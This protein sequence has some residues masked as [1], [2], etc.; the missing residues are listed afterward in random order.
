VFLK[1]PPPLEGKKRGKGVSIEV[2]RMVVIGFVLIAG[3][4]V[5]RSVTEKDVLLESRQEGGK[6]PIVLIVQALKLRK[7]DKFV[8]DKSKPIYHTLQKELEDENREKLAIFESYGAHFEHLIYD[9]PIFF[10]DIFV[11]TVHSVCSSESA[12]GSYSTGANASCFHCDIP[13]DRRDM[14][15]RSRYAC[16]SKAMANLDASLKA[17]VEGFLVI[18]ADFFLLPTFLVT[19][20]KIMDENPNS[21]WL[22]YSNMECKRKVQSFGVDPFVSTKFDLSWENSASLLKNFVNPH[23][24]DCKKSFELEFDG[25]RRD[26]MKTLASDAKEMSPRWKEECPILWVDLYYVSEC[27]F[28]VV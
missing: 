28:F 18:H 3:K 17:S 11:E 2:I 14:Y 19:A 5:T 15:D 22:P 27:V 23:C 9:T 21:F 26:V 10:E 1:L 24:E 8:N 6:L 7:V 16:A 25:A 20:R 4:I 12:I 13:Y